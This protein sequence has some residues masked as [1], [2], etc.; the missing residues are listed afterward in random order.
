M[1]DK[2][3]TANLS[4][5]PM[6]LS[7]FLTVISRPFSKRFILISNLFQKVGIR[8]FE[9]YWMSWIWN[10]CGI[11]S[12]EN[13]I[14]TIY[15]YTQLSWLAKRAWYVVQNDL[16]YNMCVETFEFRNIA[17]INEWNRVYFNVKWVLIKIKKTCR[18]LT[19]IFLIK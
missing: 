8:F 14:V 4:Y 10:L 19:L 17:K 15:F 13:A 16:L 1:D 18:H 9:L 5:V 2:A 6:Y 12:E 7:I 3:A 11:Q